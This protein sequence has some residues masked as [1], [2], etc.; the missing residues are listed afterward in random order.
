M[1]VLF[2]YDIIITASLFYLY[3]YFLGLIKALLLAG[4]Q[5]RLYHSGQCWAGFIQCPI[6]QY[7]WYEG[8]K[9]Y[10]LLIP[11]CCCLGAS[12]YDTLLNIMWIP[13]STEEDA[14]ISVLNQVVPLVPLAWKG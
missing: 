3:L 6:Q 8:H 11:P 9:L 4:F 5:T 2:L 12:Q 7:C 14:P 10:T 1:E 13:H